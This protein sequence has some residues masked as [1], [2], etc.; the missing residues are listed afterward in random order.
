[1]FSWRAASPQCAEFSGDWSAKRGFYESNAGVKNKGCDVGGGKVNICA[2]KINKRYRV[3]DLWLILY[4]I[5]ANVLSL[6]C[7]KVL[8]IL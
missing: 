8:D 1:M 2:E 4:K 5:I 7:G 6:I 3:T